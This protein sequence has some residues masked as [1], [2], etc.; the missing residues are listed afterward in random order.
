MKKTP[1][2]PA[3]TGPTVQDV[4]EL[5]RELIPDRYN[6]KDLIEDH[7]EIIRISGLIALREKELEKDAKLKAL[8]ETLRAAKRRVHERNCV[9]TRMAEAVRR[10]FRAKGLTDEVAKKLVKLVDEVNRG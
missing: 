4:D 7:P 8:K 9:V 1:R 10:E 6:R 5:F 2:D 3:P